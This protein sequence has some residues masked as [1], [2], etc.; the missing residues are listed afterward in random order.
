MKRDEYY[1]I[2]DVGKHIKMRPDKVKELI[3]SEGIKTERV[4]RTIVIHRDVLVR[5]TRIR[6]AKAAEARAF[7]SMM[8]NFHYFR[9]PPKGIKPAQLD[10]SGKFRKGWWR[11][12]GWAGDEIGIEVGGNAGPKTAAGPG[13]GKRRRIKD[14]YEFYGTSALKAIE[15]MAAE[16][17]KQ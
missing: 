2:E 1:T 9:Q 8:G 5:L 4:G 3:K 13:P 17:R 7:L 14:R 12:L 11:R 10:P 15:Q 6:W 16:L